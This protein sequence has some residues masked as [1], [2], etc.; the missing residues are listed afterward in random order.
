MGDESVRKPAEGDAGP[1][2]GE[3]AQRAEKFATL[4]GTAQRKL[5]LYILSLAGNPADAEDILQETNLVLWRKF[6]EF[7]EGTDFVAWATKVAFYEVLKFRERQGRQGQCFSDS[8][9]E[10][11]SADATR[12]LQEADARREALIYCLGKLRPAIRRMIEL[13]YQLEA[14]VRKVAEQIGR[15]VEA[16]RRALHRARTALLKCI[17]KTL[18]KWERQGT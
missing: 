17:Q 15:S 3:L 9:L 4:L 16:T 1:P 18:A 5:F 6:A 13:R 2:E 11:L 8:L 14:D 12:L 7:R 10:L